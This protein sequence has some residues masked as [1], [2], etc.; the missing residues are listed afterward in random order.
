MFHSIALPIFAQTATAALLNPPSVLPRHRRRP[1]PGDCAESMRQATSSRQF[2]SQSI[3]HF[4]RSTVMTPRLSCCMVLLPLT[5]TAVTAN[6]ADTAQPA[7]ALPQ[8]AAADTPKG[9]TSGTSAPVTD[10]SSTKI[11]QVVVT[12]QRRTQRQSLDQSP[13]RGH[14]Q[15]SK[16]HRRWWRGHNGTRSAVGATGPAPWASRR[17]SRRYR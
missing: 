1:A 8:L 11:E 7:Q 17:R 15:Q 9:D 14:A 10:T 6:A 3:S 16:R 13:P 2:V 12:S 5:L 4:L